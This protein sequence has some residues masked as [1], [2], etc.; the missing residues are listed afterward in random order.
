MEVRGQLHT[1]AAFVPV[2]VTTNSHVIESQMI[3][4]AGLDI[5]EEK[6]VSFPLRELNSELS[7]P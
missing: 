2:E 6:K 3:T 4:R 1:L 5:L 7:C